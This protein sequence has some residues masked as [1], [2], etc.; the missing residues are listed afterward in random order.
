MILYYLV[1]TEAEARDLHIDEIIT[2]EG[3]EVAA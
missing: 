3:L 1:K 2:R